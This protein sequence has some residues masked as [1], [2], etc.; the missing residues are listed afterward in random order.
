MRQ[1]PVNCQAETWHLTCAGARSF[2]SLRSL[3]MTVRW[4]EKAFGSLPEG[5]VE[6][7]ETEGVL[8]FP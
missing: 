1:N 6:R 8:S 2:D 5:A 3:R 7:S 4:T